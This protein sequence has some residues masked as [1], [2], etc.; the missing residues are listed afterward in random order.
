MDE[1][2]RLRVNAGWMGAKRHKQRDGKR[3]KLSTPEVAAVNEYGSPKM[4][5][6]ARPTLA[7]TADRNQRRYAKMLGGEALDKIAKGTTTANVLALFG[8]VVVGDVVSA[9]DKTT[10]PANRPSTIKRKGSSHPLIDTGL[11]RASMAKKV[12]V[13]R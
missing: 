7:P 9:I 10:T 6:P 5:I 8:E 1:A 13:K 12:V 3:S 2:T 11:L 4:K